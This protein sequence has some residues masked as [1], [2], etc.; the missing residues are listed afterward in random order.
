MKKLP[1]VI[2]AEL[3]FA[4]GKLKVLGDVDPEVIIKEAEKEKFKAYLSRSDV[5]KAQN[6]FKENYLLLMGILFLLVG[7]GINF[8]GQDKVASLFYLAA[9][10]AGGRETIEKGLKNLWQRKIT[11]D[12]LMLTG[13]IGAMALGE[14][15]EAALA[16]VL[17][18]I[19]EFVENYNLEK[20]RTALK[21]LFAAVPEE[22]LVLKNGEEQLCKVEEIRPGDLVVIKPGEKIPVDGVLKKG[23]IEVSQA[24]ITGESRGILKLPGEEVYAGSINLD[25]FGI[26]ETQKP[27]GETVIARMA[28]LI[29]EAQKEKLPAQTLL[30]RFAAVY[31][32]L[33]LALA[34]LV[35]F[36][37]PLLLGGEFR[38][39]IYR[40]LTFL[41]VSCPCALLIAVPISVISS[42]G[43]AAR[44]GI[45]VKGS[46]NLEQLALCDTIV[47][48]KTGTLT[49]GEMEVT[50]VIAVSPDFWPAVY[51]LEK[52]ATHPLAKAIIKAVPA[53][54]QKEIEVLNFRQIPGLGVL[55]QV[56]GSNY[57]IGSPKGIKEIPESFIKTLQEIEE[58]GQTAILVA[59]ENIPVALLAVADVIRDDAGEA[60]RNIKALGLTPVL[61]SGDS[62][63]V[64]LR[65]SE[66]LEIGKWY[67]EVL[68]QEKLTVIKELQ[69]SGRKVIMVGDGINDAPAL[70]AADAGIAMGEGSG[71]ATTTAKIVLL[72]GKLNN[73]PFLIKLARQS[74]A[75][76]KQNIILAIGL[77]LLALMAI[78]PGWLNLWLAIGADIGVALLVSLN[79]LR[80]LWLK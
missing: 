10:L 64:A 66:E 67:G 39:W 56:E 31:T 20:A 4:A 27:S 42:L 71:L 46:R 72:S 7:T 68:P 79:G 35:A 28:E 9:I 47:F 77:K 75:I 74:R 8:I 29:E 61:L 32:P 34:F 55:G 69:E 2:D 6:F 57:F 54:Y 24:A 11:S 49:R 76:V 43:A 36:I 14:L 41:V 50:E 26:I 30:D 22:A 78:L 59:K 37:P 80:V 12:L 13:L 23:R 51:S 16:A 33:V 3:D 1:G 65:V 5:P 38:L 45:V 25:G 21:E 58:K 62:K 40:A 17:F 73:I 63:K 44:R 48:D 52:R 18:G 60:I 19:S 15:T 70:A 53:E